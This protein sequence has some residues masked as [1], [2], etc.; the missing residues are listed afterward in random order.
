MMMDLYQRQ[1]R[2]GSMRNAGAY[3]ALTAVMLL[4]YSF[5]HSAQA[6]VEIVT[7]GI[8]NAATDAGFFIADKKGYF[9]AEGIEI[10]TTAFASAAGMIAPLGRNQ[11]DVGAGT[12]SAGLY[13]AVEQGVQLR[14]VADKGSVTDKLE[15]SRLV[16][17]K[18]HADSGRYKTLADLKGMT[19]A[20]A[21]PGS[22]SESSVNEALKKGGL[23]YSDVKIVYMGFPQM[24]AALINKGI[25]A[26]QSNEPTL[27]RG[28][29]DGITVPASKTVIYPGQQTAVVLYS[30][31]FA[32]K[33]RGV[34]QKFI[35]A[36]IRAVRDYNDAIAGVKLAGP[37]AD[38][39][40]TILT[41]STEIKDR[42]TF[43]SMTPFAVDPNGGVNV[44]ALKNDLVFFRQRGLIGENVSVDKVVDRS[45]SEEAVRLLGPYKPR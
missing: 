21:S 35:K 33:R 17:R 6:Q 25:D 9:R 12:V 8:T 24:L 36:Y 38:E 4:G 29:R 40:I 13:N 14:I 30:E 45:F 32:Q 34:A 2:S 1:R 44:E 5:G 7:V 41:E 11:L 42:E 18:D 15:Y 22:G 10:K 28:L 27:T 26:A 31:D 39:I 16:V 43:A 37:T 19:I 20:A 3:G 23:K